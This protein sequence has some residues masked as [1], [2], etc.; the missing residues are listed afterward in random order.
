MND[1]S[2]ATVRCPTC[3]ASQEWSDTCRRCKCDLGFLRDVARSY[4]LSRQRCF[5][6]LA[7]SRPGEALRRARRCHWLRPGAES[8]RLLALSAMVS[9]DWPNAVALAQSAE[10]GE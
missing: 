8:R 6:A 4:D 1:T 5:V 9:G 3:G 10:R 2:A 7:A